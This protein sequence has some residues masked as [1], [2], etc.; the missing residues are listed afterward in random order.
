MRRFET[1]QKSMDHFRGGGRDPKQLIRYDL[2]VKVRKPKNGKDNV[3]RFIGSDERPDRH[4]SIIRVAGW[5]LKDFR[6]NPIFVWAHETGSW[7]KSPQLPIGRANRVFK[8]TVPKA[9]LVF[10]IAFPTEDVHPFGH[11]IFQLFRH[12][13]LHATSVGFWPLIVKVVE[14]EKELKKLGLK[15]PCGLVFEKQELWELS[16]VPIPS[17]PNALIEDLAKNAPG[18]I[19]KAWRGMDLAALA[20]RAA[21]AGAD[22]VRRFVGD[23]MEDIF[24]AHHTPTT[25]AADAF[26]KAF[27]DP[28]RVISVAFAKDASPADINGG[29]G[30]ERSLVEKWL[31]E[32]KLDAA[33][34]E[35]DKI[36]LRVPQPHPVVAGFNG[37]VPG[38]QTFSAGLPAGISAVVRQ[39]DEDDEE[40]PDDETNVAD[41]DDE[42]EEE[43]GATRNIDDL[44]D[45]IEN[46]QQIWEDSSAAWTQ[47][48]DNLLQM[49]N[50]LKDEEDGD[51]TDDDTDTEPAAAP[52]PKKAKGKKAKRLAKI[53]KAH[54]LIQSLNKQFEDAKNKIGKR[55]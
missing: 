33:T 43:E 5:V 20:T 34:I 18:G 24:M 45:M 42:D 2:P 54:D 37:D 35:E 13:F 9:Q 31:A 29:K 48:L 46:G 41:E 52:P 26:K 28:K 12:R 8:R 25:A 40:D 6:T 47:W 1:V 49:A 11:R 22:D 38:F 14:D 36:L 21:D 51:D 3:L 4:N 32:H 50:D 53:K 39:E 16:A 10:D 44:I 55:V 15:G 7:L 27:S 30:W 19:A 17:N 23:R